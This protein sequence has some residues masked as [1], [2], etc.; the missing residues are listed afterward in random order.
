MDK[1]AM[2][3]EIRLDVG[4]VSNYAKTQYEFYY[5]II[6]AFGKSMLKGHSAGIYKTNEGYFELIT[7]VGEDLE[8]LY[9]EREKFGQGYLSICAIKGQFYTIP[10]GSRIRIFAPFYEGHHLMGVLVFN[11]PQSE[12]MITEEDRIFLREIC[13]HIELHQGQYSR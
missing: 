3:D 12:Y 8:D 9:E 7:S 4:L 10:L 1:S 6:Q 13:R 5:G 2:L 11:V